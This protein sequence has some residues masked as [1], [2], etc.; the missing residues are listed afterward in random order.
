MQENYIKASDIEWTTQF[1]STGIG[2]SFG[3]HTDLVGEGNAAASNYALLTR[4]RRDNRGS[5]LSREMR[6]GQL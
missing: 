1:D 3:D 5:A 4:L 2:V 6:Q